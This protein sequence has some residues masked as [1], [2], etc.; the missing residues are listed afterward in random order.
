MFEQIEKVSEGL[1]KEAFINTKSA[2]TFDD[3]WMVPRFSSLK[4]RDEVDLTSEIFKGCFVKHPIAASCM[5]TVCEKDMLVAMARS[6]GTGM[7]HR[8]CSAQQQQKMFREALIEYYN[9]DRD[10]DYIPTFGY[11][12]SCGTWKERLDNL[13][14]AIEYFKDNCSYN[15]FPNIFVCLDVAHA[16]NSH[17][18]ETLIKVNDYCNN[19]FGFKVHILAGTIATPQAAEYL[20]EYCGGLRC[21]VGSGSACLTRIV[22]G[23]GV[24]LFSSLIECSEVCHDLGITCWADGGIRG[25]AD[26]VKALG[27]GADA[28]VVGGMLA[29][30]SASPAE[31]IYSP[32]E[33]EK[34]LIEQQKEINENR[35]K[36]P[37]YNNIQFYETPDQIQKMISDRKIT[38]VRYRGMASKEAQEDFSE[39]RKSGYYVEGDSFLVDY[40]GDTI[41]FIDQMLRGVKSGFAYAGA[42]NL[43]EFLDLATYRIATFAGLQEAKPH[44]KK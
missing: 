14:L 5:D 21:G 24:P 39:K 22:T 9:G 17:Y 3:V 29:A 2:L 18:K 35:Y 1:R 6:G 13:K 34:W 4:S 41:E 31:K 11:A 7:I 15:V 30:T 26:M 28:L 40:R 43:K 37:N 32:G 33:Y 16:H 25:S 23:F 10:A 42:Y 19:N 27:V 20:Y 44:G 8:G 38:H 12:I 36:Y